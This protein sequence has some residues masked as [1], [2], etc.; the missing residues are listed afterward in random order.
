MNINHIAG[1]T[2][3]LG[4]P[5]DWNPSVPC[6]GLPVRHQEVDGMQCVISSWQPTDEEL[7][8][9][10]EG[11]PVIL[12]VA[13]NTTPAVSLQVGDRFAPIQDEKPD[14]VAA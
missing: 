3:I 2:K 5:P 11:Y 8:L 13:G 7:W 14:A 4:T 10:V 9:L 1:C 6:K 12:Y